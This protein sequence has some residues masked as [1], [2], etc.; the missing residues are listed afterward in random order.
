[1]PNCADWNSER[2]CAIWVL[3]DDT[4]VTE[5][6]MNAVRPVAV[7]LDEATRA[8]L[9]KLADARDRTPHWILRE[10]IA[11]FLEREEKRE[12]FRQ[13]ALEAW[14]EYELTG[15]HVT[16][17]EADAWLSRLEDGETCEPPECHN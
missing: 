2:H 11:E 17:S 1:M 16:Q 3:L 13:A 6:L 14:Q 10:A 4:H 12:A 5:M 7:K 15:M 9:Q 8:R